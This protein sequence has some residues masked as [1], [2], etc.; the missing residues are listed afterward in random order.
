M[1]VRD[2]IKK[3]E[4]ALRKYRRVYRI[5]DFI[6]ILII[7]Y[8]LM[9]LLSVDQL[10]PLISY[11]EVRTGN[12]YDLTGVSI[13]FETVVML[14][15]AAF[16]S[17]ILTFLI[18]I[19]DKRTAAI[20]QIEEKYPELKERLR[21]AYD[22]SNADNIIVNDLLQVVSFSLTK[23]RSSD[24]LR[25]KRITLG[26]MLILIS[27]SALTFVTFYNIHT[28]TTSE[29]WKDLI[30]RLPFIPEEENPDD[31]VEMGG[32]D[33]EQNGN[34]GNE[35]LT[36]EPTVVVVDGTEVDLSLPPGTGTG[37]SQNEES[38]EILRE[39]EDSPGGPPEATPS[40]TYYEEFPDGYE[41]VIRSY[42]EQLA[43]E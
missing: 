15:M 22:N 33:E 43:E 32:D 8:T 30:D 38:E 3:Q 28:D 20:L 29:D 4:S 10:L 37:F 40:G 16:L 36:G 19:R 18:H 14:L 9:L 2:F 42:F 34:G 23:V 1:D 17:M 35:D 26:I 24:F 12:S 41:S 31:L 39:F 11:F 6:T 25:K 21:T 27:V 7:L 5:L 13:A